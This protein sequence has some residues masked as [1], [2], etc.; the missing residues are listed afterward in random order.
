LKPT[1]GNRTRCGVVGIAA[2]TGAT[3]GGAAL[4]PLSSQSYV[5]FDFAIPVHSGAA[6]APYS[7][8]VLRALGGPRSPPLSI[9]EYQT[10]KDNSQPF[11]P[12]SVCH[13]APL[14]KARLSV[15]SVGCSTKQLH[16]SEAAAAC[17]ARRRGVVWNKHITSV[18][19]LYPPPPLFPP[20]RSQAAQRAPHGSGQTQP[21]N[22]SPAVHR[23]RKQSSPMCRW[24]RLNPVIQ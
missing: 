18:E 9:Q 10:W 14:P 19:L 3:P 17:T 7:R 5:D 2:G 24:F 22:S 12:E 20:L 11:R 23:E 1:V 6:P 21:V 16:R 13:T 4:P 15:R 8:R